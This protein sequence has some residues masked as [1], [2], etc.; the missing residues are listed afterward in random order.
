MLK[1]SGF[2]TFHYYKDWLDY[3]YEIGLRHHRTKKNETDNVDSVP[4]INYKYLSAFIYPITST[5][6]PFLGKK[7]HNQEEV[8]KMY[9]AWFKAVVLTVTLWSY[10][11][12]MEND[13]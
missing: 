2:S 8:N 3:Q 13:F 1:T 5:I 11:Y 12:V 6:K 4:N 10:P 9:N 7:G